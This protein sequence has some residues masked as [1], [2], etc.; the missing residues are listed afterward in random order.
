MTD[1]KQLLTQMGSVDM[2]MKYRAHRELARLIDRE[3]RPD[4]SE[5]REQLATEL[6]MEL[7]ATV[8]S[9]A[10]PTN[11]P[12][13]IDTVQVPK[14]RIAVRRLICTFLQQIASDK[15]VPMIAPLLNEIEIRDEVRGV[16]Q[17]IGTTA[18]AHELVGATKQL[19]TEFRIGVANAIGAIGSISTGESFDALSELAMDPDT[20]VR[21]AAQRALKRIR[22]PHE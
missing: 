16:L 1:V 15:Q 18:A 7:A 11:V 10:P 4:H 2:A 3:T 14:H 19:G 22:V 8:T 12:D 9:K 6:A 17:R 21:M 5:E 13:N 20:E